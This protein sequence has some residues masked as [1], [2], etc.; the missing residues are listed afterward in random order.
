MA[1]VTGVATGRLRDGCAAF[2]FLALARAL[3]A[4]AIAT[5][6]AMSATPVE[7][8]VIP[9]NKAAMD[10]DISKPFWSGVSPYVPG[11]AAK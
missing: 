4:A 7:I 1:E 8:R 5:Q 6:V 9:V 3:F 2:S 11:V 10:S